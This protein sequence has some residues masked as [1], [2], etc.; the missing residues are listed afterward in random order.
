MKNEIMMFADDTNLWCKISQQADGISLQN[1]IRQLEL[2]TDKWQLALNPDKCKV[3]H[4]GHDYSTTYEFHHTRKKP[5]VL[6]ET[7]EENDLGVYVNIGLKPSTQC[8][9]SANGAMSVLRMVQEICQGL[10]Q[11][12]LQHSIRLTSNLICST[13]YRHGLHTWLRT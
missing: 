6:D 1:D 3:M 11:K 5:R 13:A 4:L 8:A 2:G 9:K 7:V 10:T 12:R